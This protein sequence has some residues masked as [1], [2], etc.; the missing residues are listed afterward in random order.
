MSSSFVRK[1]CRWRMTGRDGFPVVSLETSNRWALSISGSDGRVSFPYKSCSSWEKIPVGLPLSEASANPRIRTFWRQ[2]RFSK[3]PA[4]AFLLA[5]SFW[6]EDQVFSKFITRW[7]R[8][9]VTRSS[10]EMRWSR[11]SSRSLFWSNLESIASKDDLN[12]ADR[13]SRC[14]SS[15]TL[16]A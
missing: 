1:Q 13:F 16:M 3:S 2:L 9:S 7:L 12:S 4:L 14:S 15:S 8:S 11:L 10:E 6:R 5:F